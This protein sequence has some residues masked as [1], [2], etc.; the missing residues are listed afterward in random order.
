V[1]AVVAQIDVVGAGGVAVYSTVL[2]W[3]VVEGVLV[4]G[5]IGVQRGIGFCQALLRVLLSQRVNTMILEKAL[6]L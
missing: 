6:T 1:D 3:V 5:L 2:T 4:A